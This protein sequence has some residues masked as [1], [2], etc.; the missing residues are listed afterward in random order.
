MLTYRWIVGNSTEKNSHHNKSFRTKLTK[1]WNT[2]YLR[3]DT[4]HLIIIFTQRVGH[5]QTH[6]TSSNGEKQCVETIFTHIKQMA[7][8][9]FSKTMG[10]ILPWG[11]ILGTFLLTQQSNNSKFWMCSFNSYMMINSMLVSSNKIEQHIIVQI[12]QHWI[13]CKIFLRI[14]F[15]NFPI[16]TLNFDHVILNYLIILRFWLLFDIDNTL[17]AQINKWKFFDNFKKL[18]ALSK[19]TFKFQKWN[20]KCFRQHLLQFY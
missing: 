6:R 7:L 1:L 18:S 8:V 16:R 4:A 2:P 13:I 12:L 15:W 9:V 11:I 14:A 3:L 19:L 20:C 5:Y 10:I 17:V